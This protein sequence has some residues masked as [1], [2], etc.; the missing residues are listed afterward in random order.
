MDITDCV[1]NTPLV[2]LNRIS[3]ILGA[4]IFMKLECRNPS[5]SIQDRLALACIRKAERVGRMNGPRCFVEAVDAY[6]GLSLALLGMK[7]DLRFL[8]CTPEYTDR[9]ALGL[10]KELGAEIILTPSE[11]GFAGAMSKA[12]Y[13]RK[14]TWGSFRP[15]VF[16]STDLADYYYDEAG[17]ELVKDLSLQHIK[18]D[19]FI[20]G[21]WSGNAITG[22]GRRLRTVNPTIQI[23]AVEPAESPVLSGGTAGKHRI[24]G[25]GSGCIPQALDKSLISE[26]VTVKEEEAM[27]AV[28]R[29]HCMEGILAGPSSGANLFAA[30][31]L[32]CKDEWKGRNIIS[33]ASDSWR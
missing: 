10:M 1:G 27:G 25:I 13:H 15:E 4:H 3:R 11:D 6:F 30:L 7:H 21:V 24:T 19:A 20:C 31:K 9:W 12:A 18:P 2:Y 5:G 29:L 26:V 28:R 8:F 33:V 14:D 32:A 22:I 17:A 16:E 23:V